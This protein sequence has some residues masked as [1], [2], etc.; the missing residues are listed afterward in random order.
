MHILF[1]LRKSYRVFISDPTCIYRIHK[2]TILR[3]I[4]C[5]GVGQHV[6]HSGGR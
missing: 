6:D 2:N 5:R 4:P 1:E 3:K